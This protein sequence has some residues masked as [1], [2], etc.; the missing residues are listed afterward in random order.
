M[1]ALTPNHPQAISCSPAVW[2]A[3]VLG[4]FQMNLLAEKQDFP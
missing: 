4:N 2:V 3:N 1:K